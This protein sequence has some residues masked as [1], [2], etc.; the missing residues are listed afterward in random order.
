M[1]F[2]HC[3]RSRPPD[4]DRCRVGMH[5]PNLPV[6]VGIRLPEAH[7]LSQHVWIKVSTDN[8]RQLIDTGRIYTDIWE[9]NRHLCRSSQSWASS[10]DC[11]NVDAIQLLYANLV[12]A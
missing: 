11:A 2:P 9:L 12:P 6:G 8:G 4:R 3:R 5:L 10:V 1:G 7:K